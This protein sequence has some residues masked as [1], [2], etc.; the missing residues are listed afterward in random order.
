MGNTSVYLTSLEGIEADPQPA[1]MRSGVI[2][3][4]LDI[5]RHV[6][7]LAMEPDQRC[8]KAELENTSGSIYNPT[9][10]RITHRQGCI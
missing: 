3:L 1:Y 8:C 7:L 2:E 10:L 6:C 9:S 5:A 4:L